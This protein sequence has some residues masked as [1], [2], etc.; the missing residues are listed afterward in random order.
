MLRNIVN[1]IHGSG[2][3]F[4][5]SDSKFAAAQAN[6]KKLQ[7]APDNSTKL[8]LYA[9]FKQA[10]AGD[11]SGSAPSRLNFVE[12]AKYDA[13]ANFKGLTAADAQEKYAKLVDELLGE[14]AKDAAAATPNSSGKTIP[15][16]SITNEN[17]IYKITL[18][19][20]KKFNA[21][22]WEMYDGLVDSLKEADAD[23]SV[24]LVVITGAGD[25]YCSGNDLGNF[26]KIAEV[27]KEKLAEHA[28][29]V[30]DRFVKA[31]IDFEKPLIFAVNGPAVGIAVTLLPLANLVYASDSATFHT[32]FVTLG[33]SA[34]G[35]STYN[36]PRLMGSLKAS[37]V[38]IFG[39]KLTAE[40]AYERNLVNEVIPK[41]SFAAEVDK[42]IAQFAKLPPQALKINKNIVR[43]VDREA[44]HKVNEREVKVLMNRWLSKECEQALTAFMTRK[45]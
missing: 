18:N 16:L 2:F 40:E 21:I 7:E 45:K 5:S 15:G 33:Q 24:K 28:G 10:T 38:L 29:G 32:P 30:F 8:K 4:A 25:Y 41:A 34:E 23:P 43:D 9:L 22:T 12:R 44:L 27:G 11:V 42:R 39:R 37:E 31:F 19:R 14:E 6:L 26:S 17:H 35:T 1:R 13:W 20:P 36:F 3:R